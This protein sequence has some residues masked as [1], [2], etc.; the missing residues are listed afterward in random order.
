VLRDDGG[1]EAYT[2]RK[3]IRVD[4]SMIPI[5][6]VDD[7]STLLNVTKIYMENTGEFSVDTSLS[8]EEGLTR[9]ETTSY[10]AVISDYQMPGMDGLQFLKV[11]REKYPL[12]P[13]I[14]F[15]GKGREEVA[16]EALNS[17]ADFYLQKGGEPKSQFAE[18]RNKIQQLVRRR[19]AEKALAESQEKYRDIV[20]NINEVP[21]LIDTGGIVTYISPMVSQFGFTAGEVIGKPVMDFIIPEDRFDMEER[22]ANIRDGRA[23]PYLFRIRS[24]DGKI[25]WVRGSSRPIIENGQFTGI[26]GIM[27]DFSAQKEM[28]EALQASEGHYRGI[29]DNAPMGIF[30]SKLDGTLIDVN[31]AFARMFGYD[32]EED[33]VEYVNLNG[34]TTTIYAEPGRREDI[35]RQ[36]KESGGWQSFEN[37]F[38]RKDGSVFTGTLT[39]R[40][41]ESPGSIA[42][43]EG[44]VVD[45]TESRK[46]QARIAASERR[47][48]NVF[49]S[50][51]DAMLVTDRDTGAILD[52]NS[53]ALALYQYSLDELRGLKYPDLSSDQP[54]AGDDSDT[55]GGFV[56]ASCHRKKDGMVFPVEV[57]ASTYPQKNRTI[58]IFCV[59][60]ITSR[61]EAEERIL[62]TRRLYIV[63]SRVSEAIVRVRDLETLLV[64]ICR[65]AVDDGHFR[66]VWVGLID[67][68]KQIISPVAH[69]G[70]E[71]G[72]LAALRIP[73]D[74]SPE[75]S[76]PTGRAFREGVHIVTTDIATDP[77]ME[78]WREE[79][80]KRGYRS[81]AAFPFSLHGEVVGVINLYAPEPGFFTDT[82]VGLLSEIAENVSFALGLL[83]EQARRARAEQ[84][85]AGSEEHA[86]F[87]A[88]ILGMSSQPFFVGYVD[89]RFGVT[90]PAFCD[91]LGYPENEMKNL[92]WKALTPPEYAES[93]GRELEELIATG[94]PRR[95]EKE[96]VRK[97]ASRVLVEIF[98]HRALD[99]GGN[100]R[101]FYSFVTDITERKR[102]LSESIRAKKE[103]ETIFSAIGNPALILDP[104]QTI[105]E[106]NDAVVRLTGKTR[107]ELRAMKCWQ[108]FHAPRSSGP[109][110]CC[111]FTRMKESGRLETSSME[112][113]AFGGTFLV[114][115]TP[116]MDEAGSLERVIHIATDI[117]RLVRAEQALS[118]SEARYRT[119][120]E[121]STDAVILM[122]GTILDCNPAAEQLWGYTRDRI[123]GHDPVE[124]SPVVQPDGTESQEAAATYNLAAYEWGTQFFAWQYRNNDGRLIDT[125]VSLSSVTVGGER[126]LI[127]IIR[128]ITARKHA[129]AQIEKNEQIL[130]LITDSVSDMVWLCDLDLKP[131]YISPSVVR[132]RGYT[133]EE[134]QLLPLDRR[135]MPESCALI[136]GM[137]DELLQGGRDGHGIPE[138][139]TLELEFCRKD[140]SSF[141]S[142]NTL[143]L[144]RD[145]EGKPAQI[146][147][148]GRDI[149]ERKRLENQILRL[150]SFPQ[151]NPEPVLEI[152]LGKEITFANPACQTLLDKLRMPGNPAAFLP[153]DID[154]IIASLKTKR[155][156][157]ISRE[158]PVGDAL[159]EES[160]TL[161]PGGL[162][163]RIYAHD[164]TSRHLA[165]SAL[166]RANRKLHLLTG[167]TRHDIRNRLTG[168]LGYIELAKS[169]TTDPAL[170]EYLSRSE[171]SAIGIRHQIEFTKEYENLG[172]S[173]PVWQDVSSLIAAARSQLDLHGIT[174]E[175]DVAGVSIYADPMF[176]RIVIHLIDNA[177]R[178][179]G[180][181]LS[182]IRFSGSVTPDG[183]ILVCED[184]GVGII[185]KDK[186]AIFK[187][188]VGEDTKIGLFLIQEVLALT[189]ITIRESGEPEK[190]ARFELTV[191]PGAYRVAESDPAEHL[192]EDQ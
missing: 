17:G 94:M 148:V 142:E 30:H 65:I 10:E 136:L 134:L 71:D 159:F 98:A 37:Q 32:S 106:A 109:P 27:T 151:L 139:I 26:R 103:W 179:G 40:L 191:P 155:T 15:T 72:Y 66:M 162:S 192:Y 19:A 60:D 158:V 105:L 131:V 52:A 20:E 80:V 180:T 33:I 95:Y 145:D 157:A 121:K 91:L 87:L 127:A 63:L 144:I 62:A 85:L 22:L 100:V 174:L 74:A 97:D 107:E 36:I 51:S 92:S 57:T 89:G 165:T 5:L 113:P 3:P 75:G 42:E 123:I 16:I 44:F 8:A 76:G 68:E 34:G 58:C 181:R 137:R 47:Y 154:E 184:D 126:R 29:F 135:L 84:A 45:I 172:S 132:L 83:D 138:T 120:F 141:W 25:I 119:I 93:E 43:L 64:E 124:F 152:T 189:M 143:T 169:S 130:R 175:D 2:G 111:P 167:I 28:E 171:N 1:T 18:L 128:D 78:P 4:C 168:V 112:I 55:S 69:A 102:V 188:V 183:Y 38:R 185:R 70:F 133:L 115:C 166:S 96:F 147:T 118:D 59:R 49:E 170:L 160:L 6:Y 14:L 67:K 31:P 114:S 23:M 54:A 13:F 153:A 104:S 140:G 150:A 108:V 39:F 164:I 186:A 122:N 178:H 163:V 125:D 88:A 24:R 99:S 56:P 50:A 190:G 101:Y 86:R 149:T 187:R 177:L 90:N 46:A 7:E 53:A 161:S 35:I 77:R 117:T 11:L 48:H 176:S 146:L 81:S 129:E 110:E 82:E 41:Y 12:L 116:V 156:G 73:L 21:Y 9:L 79:A 182:R 173:A 61:K